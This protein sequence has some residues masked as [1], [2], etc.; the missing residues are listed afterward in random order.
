MFVYL[1]TKLI[2]RNC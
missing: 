1:M 2:S